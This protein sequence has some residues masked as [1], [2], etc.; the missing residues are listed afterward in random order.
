MKPGKSLAG[1]TFLCLVGVF[2]LGCV[3][4]GSGCTDTGENVN[5]SG[6]VVKAGD[7][8]SVDYTGKL[9]DGTVF[10]TSIKETAIEAGKFYEQKNYEPLPFTVGTGQTIKGFD[11]G[12]VGMKVGEEKTLI[13]PP[14]EAYGEYSEEMV[15]AVPLEQLNLETPPVVGQKLRSMY[16]QVT[17]LDVNETHAT[18]DFNHELAG[19]TLTFEIKLISLESN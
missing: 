19:K 16:G 18:L 11:E 12:V 6:V 15:Q 2:L 13:I 17:V 14:E 5:E 9:D 3:L 8:I 1:K 10:D 4:L 7:S